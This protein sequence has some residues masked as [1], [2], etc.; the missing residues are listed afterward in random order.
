MRL[1]HKQSQELQEK[2]QMLYKE[3][4]NNREIAKQLEVQPKTVGVWLKH[5]KSEILETAKTKKL[6]IE[7][8]NT[9]LSNPK[10]KTT[11]IKDLF[12]SLALYKKASIV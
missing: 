9:A 3:G 7:R 6:L 5:F 8:I 11:E 4:L 12:T 2:A 1:Q 10:T